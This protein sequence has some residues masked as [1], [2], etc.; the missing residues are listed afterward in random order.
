MQYDIWIVDSSSYGSFPLF[1]VG[2][3][4][5]IIYDT[6]NCFG[7]ANSLWFPALLFDNC[8]KEA[9]VN[10]NGSTSLIVYLNIVYLTKHIQ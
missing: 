5:E 3:S 8:I 6:L 1:I 7:P 10:S 2:P 4:P 9:N